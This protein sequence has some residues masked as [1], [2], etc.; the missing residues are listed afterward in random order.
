MA[1]FL[2]VHGAWHG[3]WCWDK[4]CSL[5]QE[6]GHNTIVLDLPYRAGDGKKHSEG[7]VNDYA[8]KICKVLKLQTE[9][10]ILVGHSMGGIMITQAAEYCSEKIRKLI[11]LTA[12]QPIN[13]ESLLDL[14]NREEGRDAMVLPNLTID[15]TKGY[16]YFKQ[17]VQLQNIFYN[18][19]SNEDV[20][21]G[22]SM[23]VPETLGAFGIPIT[24]TQSKMYILNV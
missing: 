5:L 12:F 11:Y 6:A 1:T 23:L 14:A 15:E 17:E 9:P 4:V 13:G 19:C 22:K 2:L 20:N 21:R 8:N 7:T 3:S 16:S 24:V 10:V 18:D